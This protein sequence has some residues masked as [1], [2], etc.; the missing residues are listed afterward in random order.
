V[1]DAILGL[2]GLLPSVYKFKHTQG[3][4]R[5]T[6][7]VVLSHLENRINATDSKIFKR[8]YCILLSL[9]AEE[10]TLQVLLEYLAKSCSILFSKDSTDAVVKFTAMN[11]FRDILRVL[12]DLRKVHKP[13]VIHEE[14]S[15]RIVALL[16]EKL[17]YKELFE[18][19][20]PICIAAMSE[21][22]SPMQIWKFVNLISVLI[23]GCKENSDEETLNNF[24]NIDF[25]KIINLDS[26]LLKEAIYDMCKD[27]MSI[28]KNSLSIFEINFKLLEHNIQ[29]N[30]EY[31][32]FD[33]WLYLIRIFDFETSTD[34]AKVCSDFGAIYYDTLKQCGM[35]CKYSVVVSEI[36]QEYVLSG[37]VPPSVENK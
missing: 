23:E 26:P 16:E 17:N 5:L 21:F 9:W 33:H 28:F 30:I 24:K 3:E 31:E 36:L 37:L 8:R 4:D 25:L 35:H 12:E 2:A 34:A 32:L 22:Q 11:T 18:N 29:S 14:E 6:I 27:L 10:I 15:A 20:S 7:K 1:E 19:I 13:K